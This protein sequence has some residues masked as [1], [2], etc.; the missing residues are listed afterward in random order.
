MSP[1]ATLVERPTR[2][3]AWL[4]VRTD[5]PMSELDEQRLTSWVLHT[6]GHS[7]SAAP[8]QSGDC[9]F[10]QR[11]RVRHPRGVFVPQSARCPAQGRPVGWSVGDPVRGAVEAWVGR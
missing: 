2:I 7:T 9:T 11:G 4:V 6:I 5:Q 8:S 1:V 3:A 10:S